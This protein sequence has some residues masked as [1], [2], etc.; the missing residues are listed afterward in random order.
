MSTPFDWELHSMCIQWA[1]YKDDL[2][3][4]NLFSNYLLNDYYVPV[5]VLETRN[6]AAKGFSLQKL[7]F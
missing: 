2:S 4:M 3:F 1:I 6:K 5:K 7:K